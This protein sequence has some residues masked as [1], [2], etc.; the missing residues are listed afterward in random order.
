VCK[1]YNELR[2]QFV[3]INNTRALPK[4]L[5][6]ELLPSVDGLPERF[7]KRQFAARIVDRLNFRRD[8]VL[9]GEIRQHTNPKGM[10]S[11]NAMQKFVMNSASDGAVGRFMQ[12]CDKT[13]EGKEILQERAF[14]LCNE[15]FR[16]VKTVF[17][18]EW[19]G[20][21][22]KTS[23]LRHGAG[24]MA[25]GFVMDF[26][27]AADLPNCRT[28]YEKFVAGLE[29]LKPDTAWTSG[30]WNFGENLKP[31]WN[32]IENTSTD[33]NFLTDYLVRTLRRNLRR[34][35]KAAA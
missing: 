26:L 21:N 11:D 8:S 31:T 16:A 23:R 35:Q 29:V 15:F 13:P 20:M 7:T 32:G 14:T 30:T 27:Y 3:L 25:M 9:F 1:N 17:G 2:Q 12:E 19:E 28:D 10:L 24:L 6:Y 4:A 33:I 5:I 22:A 18:A 34:L